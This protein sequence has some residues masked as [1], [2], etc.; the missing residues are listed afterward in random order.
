MRR[1]RADLLRYGIEIVSYGKQGLLYKGPE[2][3]IRTMIYD[4]VNQNLGRVDFSEN[5]E[6]KLRQHGRS[7]II[8]FP[9][10]KVC[11]WRK[12]IQ[13][14]SSSKKMISIKT[15]FCCLLGFG[16]SE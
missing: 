15:R 13:R 9:E 1:L 7:S 2:R 4:F 6:E 8:I 10:K 14:K 16:F 3:A 5:R 12:S 11:D